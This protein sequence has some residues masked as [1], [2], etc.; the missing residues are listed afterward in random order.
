MSVNCGGPSASESACSRAASRSP[1]A[2]RSRAARRRGASGASAAHAALCHHNLGAAAHALLAPAERRARVR[3]RARARAPLRGTGAGGT[4]PAA[5][6]ARCGRTSRGAPLPPR[7]P[8]PCWRP[9][10]PCPRACR[11]SPP[12]PPG[13]ASAARGAREG[14]ARR[15][16]RDPYKWRAVACGTT[17]AGAAARRSA[18][19]H[20]AARRTSSVVYSSVAP[21]C[22]IA[23]AARPWGRWARQW[24]P[25]C[26][27]SC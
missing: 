23:A 10:A 16:S 8:A 12:A 6:E 13:S 14:P 9:A 22:A 11:A 27:A 20:A 24:A 7:H 2:W 19:P 15:V 26:R 25:R 1:L 4:A 17:R 5:A 18:R 21:A 3:R